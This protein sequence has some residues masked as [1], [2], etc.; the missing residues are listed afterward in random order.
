MMQLLHTRSTAR[1]SYC[2]SESTA[3]LQYAVLAVC[4][5]LQ[6]AVFAIPDF[7]GEGRKPGLLVLRFQGLTA[8]CS[9][10]DVLRSLD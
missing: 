9:T 3:D 4:S 1:C 7:S 6:H 5:A 10:Q 2:I 8:W